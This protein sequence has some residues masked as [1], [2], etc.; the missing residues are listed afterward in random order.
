MKE[1]RSGFKFD[2]PLSDEDIWAVG[3]VTV[4]WA[5]LENFIDLWLDHANGAPPKTDTGGL[6]S[7]KNRIRFLKEIIK[8]DVHN[9]SYQI[10][11]TEL[12]NRILGIQDERDKVVHHIFSGS[13]EN[14][15]Q[16]LFEWRRKSRI[17]E[18][19]VNFE[20]LKRIA[21]KIESAFMEIPDFLMKAGGVQPEQPLFSTAW[22]RICE[23]P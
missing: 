4:Q 8:R 9:A 23:K 14:T 18:Q 22:P 6:I 20:K 13:P 17:A 16:T 3:M 7:F 10:Y 5:N 19:S 15:N 1:I 21:L 2:L 12:L 11:L